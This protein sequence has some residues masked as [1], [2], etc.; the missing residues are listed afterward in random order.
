MMTKSKAKYICARTKQRINKGVSMNLPQLLGYYHEKLTPPFLYPHELKS[1]YKKCTGRELDLEHPKTFSE[2]IQ[3][4]K[5]Y[6]K[7]PLMTTLSDKLLVR[8]W[9]SSKIGDEYLVP[10]IG[11]WKNF[12]DIDFSTFPDKFVLKANHGSKMNIIVNDKSLFDKNAARKSFNRWLKQDFSFFF[13]FQLHYSPIKPMIVA[14][15]MIPNDGNVFDYK[16]LVFDGKARYIWIDSDRYTEHHRN[17]YDFDWN[18]APFEIEFPKRKE[19]LPPPVNLAKMKELAEKLAEGFPEVRVDFYEVDG[20]L[21]FGE[22]TFTSGSGQEKITPYEY[23]KIL[24]DMITLPI[25]DH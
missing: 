12:D 22:M 8:D 11:A 9:I 18:P 16:I 17:I 15:E 24:G 19:E 21:L 4:I 1:W 3:W 13:G 14:E 2:K 5:L 23:D 20:K 6:Y 25:E 7:N 10:L